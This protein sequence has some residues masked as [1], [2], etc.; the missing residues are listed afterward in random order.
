MSKLLTIPT[1]LIKWT[2]TPTDG[3]GDG[4]LHKADF[5]DILIAHECTDFERHLAFEV[6][7]EYSN[8]T[9]DFYMHN[10]QQNEIFQ[11]SD[12]DFDI[13]VKR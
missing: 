13:I 12:T 11:S 9:F 8:K 1:H 5:R 6:I 7:G 10:E 2:K 4:I 3:W